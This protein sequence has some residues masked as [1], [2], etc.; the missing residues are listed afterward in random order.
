MTDA[1]YMKLAL[2]QAEKAAALGEV[3][4]GAV[5]VQ[6]GVVIAAAYNR[7][8]IDKNAL[9]H[10][11]HTAIDIACKTLGGWRLPRCTLYV[12]LEPCLMCAGAIVHARIDR[13]VFGTKDEKTG[14]FGSLTDIN[15]LPLN[16]HPE[17][18]GGVCEAECKEMLQSFFKNLRQKKK[19]V[20][21]ALI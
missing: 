11:E 20:K 12:T 7:R 2:Q 4:V 5:I 21:G 8:E 9:S 17:V 19:T 1:E 18:L 10:A 3:P 16:H 13:V 6:D 14:A 15:T